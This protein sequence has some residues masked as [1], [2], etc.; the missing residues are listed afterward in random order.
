MNDQKITRI[1]AADGSTA[2]IILSG[3]LNIEAAAELQRTLNE[4]FSESPLVSLDARQLEEVDVT[5]L[6]TICSACK[7]AAA[8][9]RRFVLE[10]E[11]PTCMKALAGGIGAHMESPCRENN[12]EPCVFF[13]GVV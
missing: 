9:K 4:A 11:L 2:T 5:I 8:A 13:G 6:Q 10:G 7:S 3:E 12:N 1:L